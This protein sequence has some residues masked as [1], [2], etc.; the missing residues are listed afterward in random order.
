MIIRIY[1][2]FKN[3]YLLR[4]FFLPFIVTQSSVASVGSSYHYFAAVLVRDNSQEVIF[5]R[6]KTFRSNGLHQSL[7]RRGFHFCKVFVF[8]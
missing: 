4:Y 8:V 1:V 5:P 6:C 2:V 3:M 7:V